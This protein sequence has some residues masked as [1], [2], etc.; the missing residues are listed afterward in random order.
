MLDADYLG[1][2]KTETQQFRA[3]SLCPPG[4]KDLARRSSTKRRLKKQDLAE[5]NAFDHG[6]NITNSLFELTEK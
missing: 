5:Q 4:F 3:L 6:I 2:G 1:I